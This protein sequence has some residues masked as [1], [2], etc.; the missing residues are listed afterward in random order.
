MACGL[1]V[2]VEGNAFGTE[3]MRTQFY[4]HLISHTWSFKNPRTQ[5]YVYVRM[6]RYVCLGL[7]FENVVL[8]TCSGDTKGA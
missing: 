6:H 7:R 3:Q 8:N 4:H 2:R 1:A 5:A